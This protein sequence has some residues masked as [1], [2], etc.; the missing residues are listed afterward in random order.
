MNIPDDYD[1]VYQE[2]RRQAAWDRTE[3]LLQRCHICGRTLYPGDKIHVAS[4]F[5]VCPSCV[6]ELTENEDI[7]ELD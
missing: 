4:F 3:A 5:A 6:E 7:I 2:E 1:P